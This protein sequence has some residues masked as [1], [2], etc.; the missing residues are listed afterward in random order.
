[1]TNRPTTTSAQKYIIIHKAI[2][3]DLLTFKI[4]VK[5]TTIGKVIYCKD[6]SPIATNR[7]KIFPNG[8]NMYFGYYVFQIVM[9]VTVNLSD[10]NNKKLTIKN[11]DLGNRW[12]PIKT[13]VYKELVHVILML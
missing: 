2:L 4:F 10:G 9:T 5:I 13:T 6:Y 3:V 12:K 11:Y 7:K 8:F 1:M